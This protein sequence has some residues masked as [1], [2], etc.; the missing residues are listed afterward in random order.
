MGQNEDQS[1]RRVT[2][3]S[4]T[5]FSASLVILGV[6]LII[7]SYYVGEP[8]AQKLIFGIG[9]ALAPSGTLGFITNY[10]VFGRL[11]EDVKQ[12]TTD[13]SDKTN[14]LSVSINQST[15]DLDDEIKSLKVSTDFL[16]R[17]SELGLEMIYHD[18]ATA[19]SNFTKY[20]RDEARQDNG[21]LY[22]VG[23]SVRGLT[24]NISDID[25][26]IQNALGLENQGDRFVQK[27]PKKNF[28]LRILLTHPEYSH[29]RENQEDRPT[30]AIEDEIFDGLRK[31]EATTPVD[32]PNPPDHYLWNIV[33]MYKGTPTC[34]MIVAGNHML[35]NPYPY[36]EE[37]FKSFCI[38][39]RKVE[40]GTPYDEGRTI[41]SQYLRAHMEKPWARNAVGYRHFWL[42]GPC[43]DMAWDRRSC[44]GDVFVVQNASHFYLTVY[45]NGNA[46]ASYRGLPT[47]I[48]CDKDETS[49]IK[50]PSQFW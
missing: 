39:V 41:Y 27:R 18:R 9:M 8:N 17:S 12:S 1:T 43:P 42:E 34:F 20:M 35:I 47:S 14:E 37:A 36:E 26:I 16:R 10:L 24:E 40:G 15:Q 29:F 3:R 28:D 19:L 32:Y 13:L 25:H 46:K 30:G 21:R 11:M 44:Y 4:I 31:L 48:P 23:S 7:L 50:L 38:V 33:R 2:R 6:V 5:V 45:L 22:I 49:F